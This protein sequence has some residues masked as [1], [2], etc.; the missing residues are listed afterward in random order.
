M[1]FFFAYSGVPEGTRETVAAGARLLQE[2]SGE[3]VVTWEELRIDG[4]VI[5]GQVTRA[6]DESDVV[7]AE[8]ST[9]NSNV[10]FELG[11][12]IARRKAICLLVDNSDEDAKS[13]WKQ[14]GLL[15]QV[16]YIGYKNSHEISSRVGG[17]FLGGEV[18]PLWDDLLSTTMVLEHEHSLFYLPLNHATEASRVLTRRLQN[19][20]REGWDV[21]I[22]DHAEMSL[23]PLSWYLQQIHKTDASVVH[24][25]APRRVNARIHNARGSFLA[26]I[27]HGIN[28]KLLIVAEEDF[29]PP[30]DYQDL[31]RRYASSRQMAD[32]FTTWFKE[33]DL[34]HLNRRGQVKKG[35]GRPEKNLR[36]PNFYEFVAELEASS[37]SEYFVETR[38]FEQVLQ[39]QSITFV[40][41]KGV[42]K[43]ANMLQA[44]E[45]L[46]DDKRN[47]VVAIK[48]SD[49][50]LKG[51]LEVLRRFRGRESQAYMIENMWK[52]LLYS[53]IAKA[54]VDQSESRPAGV[55]PGSPIAVLRDYID[56]SDLAL[57]EDFA[58]R[59]ETVAQSL[60]DRTTDR[61]DGVVEARESIG[62][63]LGGVLMRDLRH[64]LERSVVDYDRV[65]LLVDN[66]DK[67]W[68]RQSDLD[69]LA[70]LL[71]GL[72]TTIGRIAREFRKPQRSSNDLA[73]TL[74][75]FLRSDV[76]RHMLSVAREP[77]KIRTAAISW[78]NRDLLFRVVEERYLNNG[79][80][81]TTAAKLWQD[82]FCPTV[83][84]IE[85]RD[86]I[87]ERVLP[88][89]RDILFL[90]GAA[91]AN[92]TN[93]RR[94]KISAEDL[95]EASLAYSQFALEAAL[96]PNGIDSETLSDL[97]LE[98]AGGPARLT[99][100]DIA[101]H[102]E[103]VG[104]GGEDTES[105]VEHL[106]SIEFLGHEVAEGR[107]RFGLEGRD[108]RLVKKLAT[109]YAKQA[110]GAVH[111][112]VHPA[113]WSYLEIIA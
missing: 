88:R 34:D 48:P 14:F 85:T 40:G 112:R 73:F 25:A 79:S 23:A 26:G 93:A 92:A 49:Y 104:L 22:A 10:L 90:V 42:G 55:D 99:Y 12:A 24:L 9:L 80:G 72:L 31:L 113:F 39:S 87:F 11:Y 32:L 110:K 45:T 103:N 64:L 94:S 54:A 16:G 63:A 33:F 98:F 108:A 102:C 43:T 46:R 56:S 61:T 109:T 105:A 36:L 17:G 6:I 44:A 35:T 5:I 51:L 19:I 29:T 107:F 47:L 60:L 30:F 84:G 74:A 1:Q 8:M 111:Y 71:L 7:C 66:L 3:T 2:Q 67:A 37:L 59:L 101:Q 100:A 83:D 57:R 15:A 38:E 78:D 50:E 4:R 82:Y 96:V 13:G 28:K 62:S 77:D 41:R 70:H 95:K 76:H 106:L 52:F 69:D 18:A 65:A 89:P 21:T 58:V 27:A 86:Y 75:V 91:A 53:E 97:F 68:D 20:D 81:K